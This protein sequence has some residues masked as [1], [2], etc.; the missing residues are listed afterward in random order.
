LLIETDA[1][2]Q[3]AMNTLIQQIATASGLNISQKQISDA[4][5]PDLY[6]VIIQSTPFLL[7]LSQAEVTDPI[8]NKPVSVAHYLKQ[9]P[10]KTLGGII[11][12]YTIG[13]PGKV[14]GLFGKDDRD[15]LAQ[16]TVVNSR[17]AK[18]YL[19]EKNQP[20]KG[21]PLSDSLLQHENPEL[22]KAETRIQ[23][24][25]SETMLMPLTSDQLSTIGRLKGCITAEA[26]SKSKVKTST[27]K[28]FT[29]IAT[30]HD[31]GVAEG[32]TLLVVESLTR[33]ISEY[34]TRKV[35]SDLQFIDDQLAEAEVKYRRAQQAL[36]ATTDRNQNILLATDRTDAN[37]R[38]SE[39]QLAFNVY[40]SLVQLKEQ[41][42]IK[43]QEN[44]PVFTLIEPPSKGTRISEGSK[45]ERI[46]L[47][48]GFVTGIA[49]VFG[50]PA[51]KKFRKTLKQGE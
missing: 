23:S 32:L 29:V 48:L 7:E 24:S 25:V 37:Q 15:G 30:V 4:L 39:Y 42:K 27:P 33:Y 26:M 43:V 14:I 19:L 13:L 2:S 46:M 16:E 38:Q 1:G 6:P 40:N 49:I 3:T 31:A 47:L 28:M 36:A 51:W 17:V 41:A 8:T 12:E 50:I 5:T 35:K 9:N 21:L 11:M 44:T 20:A 18:K 45:I 10:P 22:N 34:R